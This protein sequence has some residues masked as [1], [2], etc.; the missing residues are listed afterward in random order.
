MMHCNFL[1][2]YFLCIQWHYDVWFWY[3]SKHF[4]TT[5]CHSFI[6]IDVTHFYNYPLNLMKSLIYKHKK[7]ISKIIHSNRCILA[8]TSFSSHFTINHMNSICVALIFGMQC[9]AETTDEN[10]KPIFYKY[11]NIFDLFIFFL[12]LMFS[13]IVSVFGSHFRLVRT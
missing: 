11:L 10:G 2:L 6:Q 1:L 3:F 8:F 12:F 7:Q 13:L 5:I 4:L 9:V